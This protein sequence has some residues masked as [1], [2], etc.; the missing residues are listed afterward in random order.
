MPSII[1]DLMMYLTNPYIIA[2]MSEFATII[3]IIIWWIYTSWQPKAYILRKTQNVYYR[4]AK[5][6]LGKKADLFSVGDDEYVVDY[7]KVA[8]YVT[9]FYRDVPILL[10]IEGDPSPIQI[11]QSD[12]SNTGISKK[13]KMLAKDR[14][15]KQLVEGSKAIP[16][17][18]TVFII[19]LVLAIGLGFGIGYVLYPHITPPTQPINYTAPIK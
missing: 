8:Y 7:G 5:V 15:V 12:V 9:E 13:L 2:I 14:T 16:V 10:Y 18:M 3:M 17:S 11:K 6:S 1:D 4:V 19:C